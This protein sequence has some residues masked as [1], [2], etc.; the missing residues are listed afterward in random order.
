MEMGRAGNAFLKMARSSNVRHRPC[1]G[2]GKGK[3]TCV[4]MKAFHV[5]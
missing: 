3:H 4:I 2:D 5:K 1:G